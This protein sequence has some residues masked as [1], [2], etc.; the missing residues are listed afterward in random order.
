MQGVKL[1]IQES[2]LQK[3]RGISFF[4]DKRNKEFN[5]LEQDWAEG[6]FDRRN[7]HNSIAYAKGEYYQTADGQP[8][9]EPNTAV[10]SA[11]AAHAIKAVARHLKNAEIDK[12]VGFP[13][14][15]RLS[16]S[17]SGVIQNL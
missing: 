14:N 1:N 12:T 6:S 8:Y 7:A 16:E 5:L 17:G 15:S 11:S 9:V 2:S 10:D 3:K 13:R 4:A